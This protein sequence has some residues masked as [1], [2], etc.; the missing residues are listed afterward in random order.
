MTRRSG[1]IYTGHISITGS[2]IWSTR[3]RL[4]L[5]AGDYAV[6]L[7]RVKLGKLGHG[8]ALRPRLG[9]GPGHGKFEGNLLA[10]YP[11]LA[12]GAV[13]RTVGYCPVSPDSLGPL[14]YWVVSL[15]PRV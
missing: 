1:N 10:V 7:E 5:A 6:G 3:L 4:D 13:E 2:Y 12:G 11:P 15:L 14:A 9:H 8:T